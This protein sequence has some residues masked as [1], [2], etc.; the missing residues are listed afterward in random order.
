MNR[1]LPRNVWR[2]ASGKFAAR[3]TDFGVSVYIASF[4]TVEEAVRAI[5]E[6]ETT[7]NRLRRRGGSVHEMR[8]NYFMVRGP[9]PK[10]RCIGF[11]R[12]RREAERALAGLN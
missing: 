7:A 12:N 5:L 3:Y 6:R 1:E 10:R 2:T 9:S 11:Y 8:P 4:S